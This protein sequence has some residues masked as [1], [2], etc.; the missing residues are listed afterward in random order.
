MAETKKDAV[1]AV[2]AFVETYQVK[3]KRAADCLIR[4]HPDFATAD[5]F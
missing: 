4:L 3:N 2:E 5:D 1:D